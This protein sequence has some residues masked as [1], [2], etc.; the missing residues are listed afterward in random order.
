MK[1]FWLLA[2]SD[3]RWRFYTK[4]SWL[5]VLC[6]AM[7][8]TRTN[9]FGQAWI[10]RMRNRAIM[11]GGYLRPSINNR[12]LPRFYRQPIHISM[13]INKR[14][15]AKTRRLERQSN[16]NE[17]LDDI[18][19]EQTFQTSLWEQGVYETQDEIDHI[20]PYGKN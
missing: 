8:D 5:R 19:A 18:K 10:H 4:E 20:L 3:W 1:V 2:R 6:L 9:V 15:K 11:S 13:M 7:L 17:W 16:L 14:I 12:P